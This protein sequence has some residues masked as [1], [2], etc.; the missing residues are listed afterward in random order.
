MEGP[1][2]IYFHLLLD[3]NETL[4]E[5]EI[6]ESIFLESKLEQ[7]INVATGSIDAEGLRSVSWSSIV[8]AQQ[9]GDFAIT[10]TNKIS[11]FFF[12]WLS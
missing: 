2:G 9:S 10:S 12:F 5:L 4:K 1:G 3:N 6:C 7:H 8:F 11:F